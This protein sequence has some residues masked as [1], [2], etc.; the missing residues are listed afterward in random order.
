MIPQPTIIV[1]QK[2]QVQSCGLIKNLYISNGKVTRLLL[3]N[4][5]WYVVTDLNIR[6][7]L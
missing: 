4:R 3:F 5:G 7:N 6:L 2:I 1:C